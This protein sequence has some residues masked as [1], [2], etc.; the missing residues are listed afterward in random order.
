MAVLDLIIKAHDKAT[1]VINQVAA[2]TTDLKDKTTK[3]FEAMESAGQKAAIAIGAIST[4]AAMASDDLNKAVAKAGIAVDKAE[5]FKD[6]IRG[7]YSEGLGEG[8]EGAAQASAKASQMFKN[9][10]TNVQDVTRS[11]LQLQQIF[12]VEMNSSLKAAQKMSQAFGITGEEAMKH[13]ADAIQQTGDPAEDLAD[14]FWEY[15]GQMKELGIDADRFTKMLITGMKNGAFNS[16]KVGDTFK[17]MGLRLRTL[18]EEQKRAL[19]QLGLYANGIEQQMKQGGKGAQEAMDTVISRI[20]MVKDEAKAKSIA[21]ILAGGAG[22]DIGLEFFRQYAQGMQEVQLN[23]NALQEAN[24]AYKKDNLQ[25]TFK[26]IWNNANLLAQSIGNTVV[27]VL[28]SAGE[29]VIEW[30]K[31]F[32]GLIDAHP[33]LGQ[34][35]MLVLG[36]VAAIGL[37]ATTGLAMMKMWEGLTAVVELFKWLKNS[38][39]LQTAAQWALNLAT[40]AGTAITSAL[41][42][43]TTALGVAINFALGPVGLIIIAIAA[44]IGVV[45]LLYKNWDKVIAFLKKGWEGFVDMLKVGAAFIGDLFKGILHVILFP[46]NGF[47]MTINLMIKALNAI[48]FTVPDWVPIVGGKT[49]DFNLPEIPMLA[50][51]TNYVPKDMLAMIHE[52]EAVIP[53]KFNPYANGGR[54][55]GGTTSDGRPLQVVIQLDSRVV[56]RK[57]VNNVRVLT[58]SKD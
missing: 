29:K 40:T 53:K 39:M 38:T 27:P 30:T 37:L 14:T 12:D 52:G 46:F 3:A 16:D 28:V 23:M 7:L 44:L 22:E 19:N 21:S 34:I 35:I 42:V 45:I 17:E 2:G 43:A 55:I 5:E 20:G 4:A 56:G 41:S 1:Q 31:S 33:I 18:T 13:I 8:L 54:V 26:E 58:G 6:N 36:A 51:G 15:S 49:I 25:H 48:K 9:T 11:A 32:T 47:L 24:E 50:V 10:N 57:L